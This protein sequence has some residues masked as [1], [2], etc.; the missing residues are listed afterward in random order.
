[1]IETAICRHTRDVNAKT[2]HRHFLSVCILQ[3]SL[4]RQSKVYWCRRKETIPHLC[5]PQDTREVTIE[6]SLW[7]VA[8]GV[9]IGIRISGVP[10]FSRLVVQSQDIPY[11][12]SRDIPYTLSS[13]LG[14]GIQRST[15]V[16]R[17]SVR[18]ISRLRVVQ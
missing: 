18:S 6:I 3:G 1:M 10:H 5:H 2:Q 9:P 15:M 14:S 12:V 13:S 4:F 11:K 16:E 8:H 7:R 17:W